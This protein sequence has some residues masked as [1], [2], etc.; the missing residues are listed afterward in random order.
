M[1]L[2]QMD[3]WKHGDKR[4][5]YSIRA[6]STLDTMFLTLSLIQ[7]FCSRQ[8]WTYFVKKWKIS[9]I[10]WKTYDKQWKSLWQ[11]Q[12]LHIFVIS[13]FVTMFSKSCLLQ[14]LQKASIWGKGLTLFNSQTFINRGFPY[15]YQD[16][17][18]V[19]CCRN[20]CM[21]ERD[22]PIALLVKTYERFIVEY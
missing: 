13:S 15:F 4:R 8:L 18:K 5:N 16:V 1:P 11:K 20:C 22:I 21:W 19:F 17:F 2:Q 12:K 3:F 10:K 6:I 9:I 14:R 7:Q